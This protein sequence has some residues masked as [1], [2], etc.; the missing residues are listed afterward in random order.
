MANLNR[1][2]AD[3]SH[4]VGLASDNLLLYS[5]GTGN[6]YPRDFYH[7][8]CMGGSPGFLPSELHGGFPGGAG[9]LCSIISPK[10]SVDAASMH[11]FS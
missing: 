5:Y 3:K 7:L 2:L 4:D 8:N 6:P 1:M 9:I 10:L 11:F